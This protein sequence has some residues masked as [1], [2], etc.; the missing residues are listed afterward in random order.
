MN[1][2][3]TGGTGF[4]GK[5]LI[6]KLYKKGY[7][8]Y[9]LIRETS[10]ISD[11]KNKVIPVKCSLTNI[12]E[13]SE[14]LYKTDYIYYLAGV[15]K[16]YNKEIYY[17]TNFYDFKVF[18]NQ[19][20]KINPNNLKKF[21][22]ISSQAAA[23]PCKTEKLKTETDN[24]VPINSYGFS[25]MLAEKYL[26]KYKNKINSVIIRPP[27]VFGAFEADIYTYFKLAEKGIIILNG[28]GDLKFSIVYVKDLV[29]SVLLLGENKHINSGE[30]FF[31][32]NTEYYSFNKFADI[33][34]QSINK[35]CIKI[36][37]PEFLVSM[38]GNLNEHISKIFKKTML[39]NKEKLNE[40]QSK[41][42]LCSNKKFL[43]QYPEFKFT[44][45]KQSL[46]E[47]YNWY[48]QNNWL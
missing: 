28:K 8:I 23:G 33:L 35:K 39:L 31:I 7:T 9:C 15:T 47:T 36:K 13:I 20:I 21:V 41:F 17:K 1:I 44:D 12:S 10:D 18:I 26:L 29:E 45:I 16:H 6:D 32:A 27:A 38:L 37:I 22:F 40:I 30:T 11:I 25:K 5:H 43:S 48:K 4:I 19:L 3:I 24:C 14:M 2:L 42:W 34:T 46:K